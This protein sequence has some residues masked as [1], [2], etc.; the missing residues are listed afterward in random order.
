MLSDQM[1]VLLLAVILD[2]AFG[3]P[4]SFAHPVVWFGK[5]IGFFD[6]KWNRRGLPDVIAGAFF[7][8]IVIAFALLLS[9]SPSLLPQP[10]DFLVSTYLLFSCISIRSM[11][12]HAKATISNGVDAKK[13]QM[14]VSRDTS[15]LSR[16]QLCSAVI[17]SVAENFVD[18]VLAP[19]LY[20]AI[21]GL[22]GAVVYR[23]INVCDAMVGY[24]TPEY[25]KFGKFA[26][27]IDDAANFIP[28]RLSV[29]LFAL[30]N[31]RA[32]KAYRHSVKLNGHAMVAMAYTLRVT[33]EK[34][35]SYIIKAG[36][37]PSERDVERSISVF[38]MVSCLAV[39]FS[40]VLIV[41]KSF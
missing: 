18:G 8:F 12:D 20:F 30:L 6:S 16:H 31:P 10:F 21:F 1:A 3:E 22:P 36:R 38:W 11:V 24:R 14:I 17:E 26:A 27:R 5:L 37:L 4:P 2:F 32:L 28:A 15:K 34:P 23:A 29:L 40:A 19:L 7:T 25:E 9:Q 13:V 33:L 41:L 39:L 35:G